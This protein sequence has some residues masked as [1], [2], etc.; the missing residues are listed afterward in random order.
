[1]DYTGRVIEAFE[2]LL[3]RLEKA[4]KKQERKK[5]NENEANLRD[6]LNGLQSLAISIKEYSWNE[7]IWWWQVSTQPDFK[8]VQEKIPRKKEIAWKPK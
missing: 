2:F 8:A 3:R 6:E 7:F 4:K 5:E 1:M